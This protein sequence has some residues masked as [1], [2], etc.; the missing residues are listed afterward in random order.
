LISSQSPVPFAPEKLLPNNWS[1]CA[2]PDASIMLIML[3]ARP[4]TPGTSGPKSALLSPVIV[5]IVCPLTKGTGGER[6]VEKEREMKGE[7]EGDEGRE[8]E[9]YAKRERKKER[10]KEEGRERR[11]HTEESVSPGTQN[12]TC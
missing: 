10:G 4:S 3:L 2:P 8:R 5:K 6:G 11:T 12:T 9:R 7:R 1:C